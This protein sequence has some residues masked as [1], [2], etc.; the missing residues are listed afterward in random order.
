MSILAALRHVTHYKYDRPVQL[1]PQV[2]RLRPAPHS[3]TKV[4][5]F[6][7]KVSPANHFINWQQDP[8]GN[9]LARFV[10]PE[11]TTEFKIEVDLLA[12]MTV[13]NPFDFFVEDYASEWPFAYEESLAVDLA[14]YLET[15]PAGP[16]LQDFLATLDRSET[17]TVDFLVGLN[18]VLQQ[19]TAYLIRMEP[20]VQTPEETLTKRSGS[21][22]DTTWLLVQT[23]RHLGFAAR[24]VS[25]YLIQ[26]KPDLV[27]LDGPAGTDHDFTDL[28]AWTE[29]YLPGAGWI[30]LDATSGLLTGESHVPLA[31]TPHYRTAAPISGLA[32]YAEVEFDF[33]MKVDRIAERP[34][35]SFPFSDDSWA[36]LD[37]L[38]EKVDA[39][40]VANDVRLTMGGEPTFV[41]IDDFQSAEWNADATGPQKRA[42]ADDLIRRLRDR[43]APGGFLHYGQGKWYPGE[44]LPRWTF[45]L[46]WRKDGKPIWKNPDLIA[47]EK[48]SEEADVA[49]AEV[50]TRGVAERLGVA[51]D[52]AQAAYEDPSYWLVR[53]AQLPANVDPSNPKLEDAEERARLA[54]VFDRGLNNPTGFVLPIQAWQ[55]QG[56]RWVSER[57]GTRR[58][59]LFLSPGD[60]ALGY[61]LPLGALP[62]LSKSDFPYFFPADPVR[63]MEPLPD[64]E[65]IALGHEQRRIS[66]P[67]QPVWQAP[68]TMQNEIV[69]YVRTALSVE[70]RDGKLCVFIPP[71]E[72]IEAYLD[73]LAAIEDTAE[74]SGL[75]VQIE[76][77]APPFDPRVNVVRVAPDPGV[78]EVN[79]HPAASWREAVAITTGVYDDARQ[80]RLGA[81]KFMI[82]GK[83]VGTGGGNHVVVGG[84]TPLDSP[85]LR[86]PDLLKSLVLHWQRHPSLSYL[87]SGLFIGPTSQAPRIDEARHDQ[88]YELEIAMANVPAPGEGLAP[89]PWLVDRLFRN[90]LIDVTGNT[91]RSEIC[92]DKLYSPDGPTGRLGLVEFRGFEM[93]PDP[94]MSLAQQLL[95]RAMIAKF[96][97]EPAQGGFVRWGTRLAD[98]FMLPAFVWEDFLDVLEDLKRSGYPVRAEWFEAQAEFRFPFCGRIEREGV[99]L[100]L[101]QALEPWHVMGETGAIGGTVRFVDSSV[102]RLQVK[103]TNADPARHVVTCNG[104]PVPLTPTR[105]SGEQVAGVRFKAWQPASG[106]HPTIP[107]HAPLTF[108]IY[109]KWSKRSLGG[110]VY[111]VAHPGGRNYDTFPV[112]SYEAEARRL[113]RFEDIG[114]TGGSFE[115]TREAPNPTFPHTLDLRRPAWLGG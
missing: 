6:S 64:P 31:A 104:R 28:H 89:P 56:V 4:P 33:E 91:H 109:D 95:I 86:R 102:E 22:R 1:G 87:F 14:P 45:S 101:R 112:N 17:R 30:G 75:L 7:L 21:C 53:E 73:L 74:E 90:L 67:D 88:L 19:Q 27:S 97:K 106:L 36:A 18:R 70:P 80:S 20:G 42:L 11:P 47:R 110:C 103:L 72:S 32:S 40:L 24:F 100:E 5:S 55:A 9:Y 84:A 12:D 65:T 51:P 58:G 69:G 26:L 96:W 38:G 50:L 92:I 54:R 8:F 10:F 57:W 76:G 15:E 98:R 93:P 115:P 83:H 13:Y 59:K 61:R 63:E 62:H 2:I 77:Y 111:H 43:F 71:M 23:L 78:I 49:G 44:T 60:S 35:V 99:S 3:R 25:G 48:S 39:E 108:D 29:V 79:V 46:Y 114:H 105:V 94:R 66:T 81:D 16:L 37:A 52:N 113:A 82:D 85:F 34:R 41:S 68:A 107:A